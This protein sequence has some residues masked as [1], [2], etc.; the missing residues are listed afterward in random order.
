MTVSKLSVGLTRLYV[1]TPPGLPE[2]TLLLVIVY[3]H[4]QLSVFIGSSGAEDRVMCSWVILML[5]ERSS[6]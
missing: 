6:L 3:R 2:E 4:G 1:A 5:L